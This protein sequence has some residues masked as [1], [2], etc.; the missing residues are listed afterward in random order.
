MKR[1]SDR[2]RKV[3]GG[4]LIATLVLYIILGA[5]TCIIYANDT[6]LI[7]IRNP[8]EAAPVVTLNKKPYEVEQPD[9]EDEEPAGGKEGINVTGEGTAGAARLTE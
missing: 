5:V 7:E 6:G 1:T 8:F 3:W 2:K 4:V 9:R